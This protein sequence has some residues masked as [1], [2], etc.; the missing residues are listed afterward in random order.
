MRRHSF[1]RAVL[2]AKSHDDA[3]LSKEGCTPVGDVFEEAGIM[4][5]RMERAR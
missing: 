1:E 5:R 3:P 4:H 2:D